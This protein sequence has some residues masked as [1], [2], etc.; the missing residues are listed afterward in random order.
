MHVRQFT[1]A[2]QYLTIFLVPMQTFDSNFLKRKL[3]PRSLLSQNTDNFCSKLVSKS[4]RYL[5]TL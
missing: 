5:I 2:M 4:G 3:F 1:F